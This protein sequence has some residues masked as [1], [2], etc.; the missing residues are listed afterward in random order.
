MA[1]ETGGEA[2]VFT[3]RISLMCQGTQIPTPP[4]TS[5][6]SPVRARAT[7]L[8]RY[9]TIEPVQR[10]DLVVRPV[11]EHEEGVAKRIHMQLVLDRDVQPSRLA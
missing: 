6:L 7:S 11:Y 3:A 2:I 4:S 9:G 1:Y 5:R 8:R 10:H